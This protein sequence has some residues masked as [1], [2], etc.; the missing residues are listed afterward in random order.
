[1]PIEMEKYHH[2]SLT[3]FE[4]PQLNSRLAKQTGSDDLDQDGLLQARSQN[5][6]LFLDT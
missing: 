2:I 3:A 4:K 5:K 1:M 6:Y